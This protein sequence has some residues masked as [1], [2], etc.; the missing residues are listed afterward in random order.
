MMHKI[1][2]RQPVL[3]SLL[4]LLSFVMAF[5]QHLNLLGIVFVVFM[6]GLRHSFDVDH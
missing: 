3:V 4:L 6:L 1:F 2:F 5:Y